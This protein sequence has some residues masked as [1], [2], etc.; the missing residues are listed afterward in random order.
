[1]NLEV[2]DRWEELSKIFICSGSIVFRNKAF[3]QI[4]ACEVI[5]EY[6]VLVTAVDGATRLTRGKK[7]FGFGPEKCTK[8]HLR[9]SANIETS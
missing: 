6:F 4:L 1:M 3:Q 7:I 9:S 2:K 8:S 5:N